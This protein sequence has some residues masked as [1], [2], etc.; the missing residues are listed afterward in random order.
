MT[1][2]GSG[3][4]C[5]GSLYSSFTVFFVTLRV[6]FRFPKLKQVFFFVVLLVLVPF[7]L[8]GQTN[9]DFWFA[10]PEV[11][12]AHGD[13]PIYL[14]LTSFSQSAIVV[15][16]EPANTVANFPP[17]TVYIP[18]NGS[19]AVD[20]TALKDQVECKPPNTALNLGLYI[21]SEHPITA[22]YEV[23]NTVNP[24]IFILKGNNALGTSFFIPSQDVLYNEPSLSPKAYNSFDIIATED[25]TTVT[26]T[27]RK[28]IVGHSA[29]TT[30]TV[31]LDK[32]QV[33]SAQAV[34]QLAADHLMGSV[35]T[36]DNP[37]AITVK[38]DSDRYTGLDCY[39]LTGDQIVP[40]NIIGSQYI[41]VRGSTN[42][43]I[44]DWVFVTATAD[45]T[46]ITVNGSAVALINTGNTYH[47]NMLTSNLCSYVQTD[48]PVYLYHLTGYGCETGTALL[49]A[50]GCTGSTQVAFTRTT[51]YTFEM[52]I[53]TKAGAQGSFLLDGN[54]ALVTAAMFSSVPSNSAY[55]YT[56]ITFPSG[57]LPVGAHML[58]NTQDIFH[59]GIIHTYDAGQSGCSYGYFSDFASLNLGPDQ[60]VCAG[61]P[62]T[63]DAGPNRI[64]YNWFYNGSPF[65]SG[66]QTITVTNPGIYSVTVDDHGCILTDQ[67]VLSNYPS[68]NPVINGITNF[69]QGQSQP[70]SVTPSYNSY[71]WS[72]GATTQS[73][74]VS[75]SG[76]YGVT[77]TNNSGCHESASATVTVHA[78]PVVTLVQP[79]STCSNV[80]PY[81]LTG[82]SPSGGIY[83]GPGV[84]STTGYFDPASG[85]GAHLITYTFT[86]A[87]GCVG[88]SS[89]TLTVNT[90]PTVQ[91]AA[92]PSVCISA[93][94]FLLTGGTP[95]GGTYSG[96]GVN[97]ATGIFTPS[98]GSGGHLITYTY[99]DG[100]ICA[101]A[102]SK[103]LTVYPL[104]VVQ[105]AA[106]P[107]V[108]ISAPPFAL[109]GGVPAG[110]IYSGPGVNPATGIFTPASGTGPHNIVYT[111][112][113]ANGCS[114]AAIQSLVVYPLPVIQMS[115][116]DGTCVSA[117]PF[118]LTCGSPAGGTYSGPGVNSATGYFD[119]SSGIGQHLITYTY[120]DI[121]GCINTATKILTVYSSPDVQLAAQAA[122]CVS[123]PPYP[124]TGGTPAGGIYSG[125]GVN[126]STGYFDPSSGTGA[127]MILYTY[128]DP[129]GCTSQASGTLT[130]NQLPVVQLS[131]QATVCISAPPY[132][133][134]GGTPAG[135]AY[136]G[137][138]VNSATGFFDPSSG[139]GIHT[140]TYTYMNSDGCSGS[141][142]KT[143]EVY[144]LPVVQL[145]GQDGACISTPPFL[146]AFGTPAGGTYS[147]PGVN[148]TTGFF[149][150]SSGSGPHTI[151]Y[152][153]T[154]ANGCTDAP[155]KILTVY[156]LPVILLSGQ[157]GACVSDLPFPLTCGSPAGG[158]YS[159]A[160]VNSSTGFF[161]PA[162]G[163]GP[164]T[165]T[166]TLT[167]IN[168]CTSSGSK[169]LTV[170]PLPVVQLADQAPVCI[171]I[172]P[173]QLTGGTPIGGIYS[174]IGVNP[175]TGMFDPSSGAGTHTITYT[176]TGAN[177]CT[178]V[179]TK[180]L[181]V[182]P[183]PVVQLADQANVCISVAAFPLTGGLPA[184]G[185]YSGAG[186]NSATGVF[187]PSSGAGVHTITYTINGANG[188]I[189]SASKLL[190]VYPL[191]LVQLQDQA[192]V[193]ISVPPFALTGGTPAGGVYSGPGVNSSTGFFNPGSGA[194][195]HL[196]TYTCTDAN[197]CINAASKSLSVYS[198]PS[199]TL[200]DQASVCIS[201]AP[202]PLTG[203]IPA[204]GIYS[205]P[206]VN[207]G[208]GF[209]DPYSGAGV[210]LVTYTYS[211]INGC[212]NAASKSL[213]VYSI[214]F[215]QLADQASICI[216]VAPFALTGGTPAGGIYSGPGVNS[217][218]SIFDPAS[219]AG[220][221][222]ITYT[223]TDANGCINTAVKTLTVY[224]LPV[225]QM[226]VQPA[227]CI[228]DAPFAL[229]GGTPA[230]GTYS[231]TGVNPATGFFDPASG[232]GIH[233]VTYTYSDVHSCASAATVALSVIPLPL[234]AGTVSGPASL[235]EGTLNVNYLLSGPD[236]L[237][238]S[239]TW[240]LNPANGGTI[241]GTTSSPSVS[242]TPG[243]SGI[244]GIRFRPVSNCGSGNFSGYT[245]ITVN[246][247]PGVSFQSCNDL[248]TTRGSQPF[249]LRGGTP[250]GGVYSIDGVPLPSG[251]LDPSTLNAGP[252]NHV[253]S[254]TYTNVFS[255]TAGKTLALKVN[256]ASGFICGNTLTDIRDLATYPTFEIVNGATHRCWMAA[257]LNFGS[258]ITD[259]VVQT[260]NCTSEKYCEGNT[261][262]NCDASGG[263]YQWDELMGYVNAGNGDNAEGG[264]NSLAEG[265]QGICPPEWHVATE[266][267][268]EELINYYSSPGIAGM[269]LSDPYLLHGFHAK[270][271]GVLY[272]NF[273]W[274]FMPPGFSAS[275]F[276]T[277]TA[278][279]GAANTR[280]YSHGLNMIT[281][282]VSTYLSIR[283]NAFQ[284]R[285]VKD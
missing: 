19:V 173:F 68:T 111:Y 171:S 50:I 93:S 39:D 238:T 43:T 89:K 207:S 41:V 85:T 235:C 155:S 267:E 109:T 174:G 201:Q 151:T 137:A 161:D 186:V 195:P 124:L 208:T 270:T 223:Y 239:F 231:G 213:A 258:F 90:P 249:L 62:I 8:P 82:G 10:A 123:V 219:G 65:A 196:I 227:V 193:C 53:L 3:Q 24:E 221:H 133:L 167:E 254:Y 88:T 81:P 191:P 274:N 246:P 157:D 247:N 127:H 31:V 126:S 49:P 204:G 263:L 243:F 66:V 132:L 106:Q 30:F 12:S 168:G 18:P 115:G 153:Y 180:T 104:P 265:K 94:P 95:A 16:S 100:N 183:L 121:H 253:I 159:G 45:N 34:G 255:C 2:P 164:H 56:K 6:R 35:V 236:P 72:T 285:C 229:T 17:M 226:A 75:A 119:P 120:S 59:M 149:D 117:A 98:S 216:S 80:A 148:S 182:Y 47:F 202:F 144:P 67:A 37:V 125:P 200:S 172:S 129:Y 36:S 260:D 55:V 70:L 222:P 7:L 29:G 13:Q 138:G 61:T 76:I 25:N 215:V 131:A 38:D 73:I 46:H 14:R 242:L 251:V 277:S 130:V 169:T 9:T 28:D 22:Y 272:Q 284:V 42:S 145:S 60:L 160:G 214:P 91:L 26:I 237:A 139:A 187:D 283:N 230:G 147:G 108:C 48:H 218:T 21:H 101:N 228:T 181:E 232:A 175:A 197:G 217:A 268:W 281:P 189:N 269:S 241:T 177:S 54:P 176:F 142:V 225:V 84:N 97:P 166:Y 116:Q 83:S 190:T 135:G 118:P 184:G 264:D 92:Q 266:G 69:C 250:V 23:A 143:L 27:P 199:V 240:E 158:T 271:M 5:P 276:W 257:N 205:G 244:L 220:P 40:V 71:Q 185:T 15:I 140:I 262:S 150:P 252:P 178:S 105:L 136:S 110:G 63:F 64:S 141:D 146:L 282:S 78:L 280:V 20:L 1:Y 32:G 156:P 102:A 77:I 11:T 198:L 122:V 163:T 165:I 44:N 128:T 170:Y 206:G 4:D 188:C 96:P 52:I 114:N 234:P 112:T 134:T 273:T 233:Q 210:H 224:A 74:T 256:N 212:S 278:G 275:L 248:V 113:D 162:S 211:D 103:T 192:Q 194:G 261:G 58:T 259:N 57:T 87:S 245:T 86:D 209:F 152:T 33:Y 179:A 99:T 79:A 154:D 107:G 51:S 203:G 279:A